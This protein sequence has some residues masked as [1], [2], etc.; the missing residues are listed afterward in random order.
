MSA[1]TVYAPEV[2][3][4]LSIDLL[5]TRN[6]LRRLAWQR[7]AG[8]FSPTERAEYDHLLAREAELLGLVG[9]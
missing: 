3:E 1:T 8:G 5:S 7:R 4:Q 9:G 2:A 6:Q